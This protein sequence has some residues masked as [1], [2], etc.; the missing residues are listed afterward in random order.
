M[1]M[2]EAV[3]VDRSA[4]PVIVDQQGPVAV[5]RLNAPDRLNAFDDPAVD[6]LGS[7][8]KTLAGDRRVRAVVVTGEGRAFSV[9]AQLKELIARDTAA[10]LAWNRRL[11]DAIDALAAL[12]V[13]TIAA[14]NG[15][16]LG[17]GLELAL[18]CTLRIAADRAVV[19]LPEVKLGIL[20]GAG[21]T[22]RL[23]R[24][25][26]PGAALQL[27]LTG[28]TLRAAEAHQ[29]GIVDEVVPAAGLLE[30]S[31]ALGTEIAGN[32]PLAVAAILAAVDA[33]REM[34][35]DAAIRYTETHLGRL[36]DTRDYR[37]GINAFLAKRPPEFLSQ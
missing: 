36:F 12:P 5:L 27:L 25:I 24:I 23:P 2:P 31:L 26:R 29:L 13:P 8:V 18:A 4:G 22:Q 15:Y 11:N 21:G 6:A 19:G 35:L 1:P 34:T 3:Q 10:N 9:G 33:G 17:G 7:A 32:A 28:R 14:I 30:R 37:E 20:P 16:A